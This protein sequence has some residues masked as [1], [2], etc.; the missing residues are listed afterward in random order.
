MIKQ[1]PQLPCSLDFGVHAQMSY[2][3]VS[4]LQY[5]LSYF[6]GPTSGAFNVCGLEEHGNGIL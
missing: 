5:E 2:C 3:T 6:I 1:V 4:L